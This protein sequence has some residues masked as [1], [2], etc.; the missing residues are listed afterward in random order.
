MDDRPLVGRKA[1]VTGAG[2]GLGRGIARDLALAG[3]DVAIL[4]RDQ[5]S[6]DETRD[7]LKS[8]G[9]GALS[10]AAD[11]SEPTEIADAFEKVHRAFGR[12]DI[13][14]NNAGISRVGPETQD[15]T[16]ED[17]LDSIAVM[18]SGVLWGMR[19]AAKLMIP[20]R[21]GSIVNISSIR[22]FSPRPGRMTY[23]PAKAAV[24]MMTKIAAGEWGKYGL[25]VNAIAPGFIK[26]AMHD[27]DVAR[28]TFDEASLLSSIPLGR[29][30][31]PEDVGRLVTFLCSDTAA[32]ITGACLVIDGG[33]S[34][35][36]S[37]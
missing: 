4:E 31:T 2:R 37:A 10:I 14:V 15:V 33:L 29:L 16:D 9:A 6:G 7:E 12:L 22:G 13:L 36:P 25:R 27:T 3:A 17:W 23:S 19:A 1:I 24:V 28:G 26:T 5:T 11:V 30:G 32:Y 18:Q 34:T 35:I 20:Q 8:M 21:A